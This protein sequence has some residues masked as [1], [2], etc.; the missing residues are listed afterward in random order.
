MAIGVVGISC[1]V[2]GIV[3]GIPI[4]LQ[5]LY[6]SS[7]YCFGR[8][9][10]DSE[11][12]IAELDVENGE[13]N[14]ENGELERRTAAMTI[15]NGELERRTAAMT[16]QMTQMS[17]MIDELAERLR[18]E[19]ESSGAPEGDLPGYMEFTPYVEPPEYSEGI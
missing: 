13:L 12:R 6:A 9:L 3:V 18:R 7:Y 11:M 4:V 14:V 15:Q 8:K 5:I 16:I 19:E 17:G 10:E 1:I 2:G